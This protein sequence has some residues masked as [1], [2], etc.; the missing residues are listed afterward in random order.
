MPTVIV[1]E[2]SESPAEVAGGEVFV[3]RDVTG[4]VSPVVAGVTVDSKTPGKTVTVGIPALVADAEL[5]CGTTVVSDKP[6]KRVE[7]EI[8]VLKSVLG[9]TESEAVI[10]GK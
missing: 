4:Y 1:L 2:N 7:D 8:L 6:R 10:S 3:L 9:C 5:M